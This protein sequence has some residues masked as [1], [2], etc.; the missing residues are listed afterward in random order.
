M[1][2][3]LN[4]YLTELEILVNIDSGQDCITEIEK[5]ADFF[6]KRFL[7]M[8]WL[9]KRHNL[10]PNTGPCLVCVNRKAEHYDIM[11]LGH[12]D[13]VF[14]KGTAQQ[15]PFRHDG[16]FA[17]GPGVCDMKQGS[18][19][20][21]YILKELPQNILDSLNILAIFNP[22]EE[23]GSTYSQPI[24]FDLAAKTDYAFIYEAAS[25]DGCRCVQ[26]KGRM[27]FSVH[28]KGKEGHCGFV[29]ENGARSAISE[30][31]RWITRLG[32]LQSRERNTSVNIGLVSGGVGKNIVA[33]EAFMDADIRFSL[34]EEQVR[35]NAVLWE[36]LA[37]AK[38]NG[39]DVSIEDLNCVPALEP[40]DKGTE[41]IKRVKQIAASI[42]QSF[43]FRLRGGL[44][45]ANHL[46]KHGT[47]CLDAMGPGGDFDH[48]A[49]EYMQLDSILPAFKLST[50]LI[51]DIAKNK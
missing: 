3:D 15:R 29:F 27:F 2:M 38:K 45:D 6:E 13:T 41:Y 48:S 30:M 23:I 49:E 42:G 11:L 1:Q 20:M 10:Q 40:S 51:T 19:L 9:T 36:L 14:P 35:I 34:S 21:Y 16:K 28:F 25:P 12:L 47:I 24:L 37:S 33:A 7:Q 31:A 50:V 43:D 18:L 39:I 26:R 5:L 44:S 8:G 4:Q 22:D 46:S 17:Y 32:S